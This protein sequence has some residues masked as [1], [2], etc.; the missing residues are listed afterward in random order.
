M[1]AGSLTEPATVTGVAVTNISS[2]K[3]RV[4]W[5][6]VAVTGGPAATYE[7][8]SNGVAA[9][10][11][12]GIVDLFYDRSS[13]TAST[14]YTYYVRARNEAGASAAWSAVV[15][16]TT[17]AAYP[18]LY[19]L[20]TAIAAMID[21]LTTTDGF[22]YTWGT[23][24]DR[25]LARAEF[26]AATPCAWI[27]LSPVEDNLDGEDSADSWAYTNR[28]RMTVTSAVRHDSIA[29]DPKEAYKIDCAKMLEDLKKAFGNNLS[30]TA[31]SIAMFN[32]CEHIKYTRS[33]IQWMDGASDVLVPGFLK[34]E[35]DITYTQL[36]TEP[37]TVG[38]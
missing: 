18:H 13:L 22:W 35:W 14:A 37:T 21:G 32:E 19:R 5:D 8:S 1:S 36:R 30:G 24:T 9:N 11:A 7:L 26:G 6:M 12:T 28:V 4:S 15:T 38:N 25:D 29:Q 31:T 3:Q 16:K 2:T 10:I 34:S 27:D 23:A 17:P 20:E 33:E